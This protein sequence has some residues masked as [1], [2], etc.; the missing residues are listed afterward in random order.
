[1]IPYNIYKYNT[2]IY[3]NWAGE[4]HTG[5]RNSGAAGTGSFWSASAPRA[6]AVSESSVHKFHQ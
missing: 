3:W 1:M 2:Y 4:E 5:C 6:W